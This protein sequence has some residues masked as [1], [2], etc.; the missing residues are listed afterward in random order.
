MI[1]RARA[2]DTILV[3]GG[4]RG[5]GLLI[6]RRLLGD[7]F[8]VRVLARDP[9]RA[10]AALGPQVEIV[11]GDLTKP[12]SLHESVRGVD[13]IIFT[14]GV[15]SGRIARESLVKATDHDGV[16][17]TLRAAREAR[18]AGRF[19]YLN[20]IGVTRSSW[21]A[22]LL[23]LFKRNTLVWRRR[24]EPAIRNSG[25]DYTIIRVGFLLD[26]APGTRRVKVSQA[27]LPLAPGNRIARADAAEAFVQALRHPQ[28]SRTT[29]DVVW[30]K[31]SGQTDWNELLGR[32]QP[33]DPSR[34]H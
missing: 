34:M 19:V 13:H 2:N 5:V 22:A 12:D 9:E 10:T 14:A 20:S 33:D 25:I 3:I 31:T 30:E 8:R 6:V 18:F 23:N 4:T 29:F 17:A 11:R 21:A 28:A 32:L 15:H 26:H 27:E 7:G 1:T 24:I 16:L